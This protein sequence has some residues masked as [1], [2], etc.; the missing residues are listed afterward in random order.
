MRDVI[1]G[2][3]VVVD[4]PVARLPS[5]GLAFA[6]DLTVL[7]VA[8]VLLLL[9]FAATGLF[10]S[11]DALVATV[12]LVLFLGIFVGVPVTVETLSRGRSLGKMALGLRVVR[13]DG[14]PIRF[15]HALVR[16]LTGLIADFGALSGFT[17]MIALISSLVSIR[18]QR[19]GDRLAGTVV[20]RERVPAA[21]QAAIRMPPPL[22]G[23]ATTLTLSQLPDGLALA[24]RQFLGRAPRLDPH[25]RDAMGRS[26]ASEV[27]T[28]VGPPPPPGTPPE[29]FLAAVLAERSRRETQRLETERLAVERR[30]AST[31]APLPAAWS[32][33][34]APPE[35]QPEPPSDGFAAPR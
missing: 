3:A 35:S 2:D 32:T 15:R 28:V 18:G 5:R 23:W 9:G 26:L 12:S 20:V 10:N 30:Q 17:G 4:L 33:P 6:I 31:A 16:G 1:T 8:F 19:L 27:A 21:P 34:S 13:D 29:P 25:A 22:A 7:I 14:G 24:A 11:D